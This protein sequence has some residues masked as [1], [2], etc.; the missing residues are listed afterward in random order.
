MPSRVRFP[1]S[2]RPVSIR[3]DHRESDRV[4]LGLSRLAPVALPA[5]L[6]VNRVNQK[7]FGAANTPRH[8]CVISGSPFVGE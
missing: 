8:E 5:V 6:T 1:V 4:G 7:R 2:T 3:V